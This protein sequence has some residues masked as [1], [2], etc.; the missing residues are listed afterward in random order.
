MKTLNQF[1]NKAQAKVL[2]DLV[3]GEEGEFFAEKIQQL[4]HTINIMPKSYE[5]DGMGDEAV[6]HLHYFTAGCDWYITEKDME[7]EQHQA[8][9]LA[10]IQCVELGYISIVEL[11]SVGAELDLHYEPKTLGEIKKELNKL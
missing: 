4:E 3:K 11:L 9:G 7:A 5:T 10:S 1:M 2:A 8:F 6:A